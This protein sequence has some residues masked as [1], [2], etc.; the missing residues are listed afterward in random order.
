MGPKTAQIIP[1]LCDLQVS[2]FFFFFLEIFHVA[3]PV[4][5]NSL[6]RLKPE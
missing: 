6:T 5:R 4:V 3:D 2:Q 1:I